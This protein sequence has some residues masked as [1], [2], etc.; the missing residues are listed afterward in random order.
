MHMDLVYT[1]WRNFLVQQ[2]LCIN[3]TYYLTEEWF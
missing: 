3:D 2:E 1:Q